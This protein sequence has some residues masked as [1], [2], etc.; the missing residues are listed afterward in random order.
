MHPAHIVHLPTPLALRDLDEQVRQRDVGTVDGDQLPL[1]ILPA[2]AALLAWEADGVAQV[3]AEF[4]GA[5]HVRNLKPIW[6]DRFFCHCGQSRY[7]IAQDVGQSADPDDGRQDNTKPHSDPPPH[8]NSVVENMSRYKGSQSAKAVE[9]DFPH[10][11]DMNVPVGGL[12][13]RLDAMYDFHTQ[14]GIKPQRGHGRH[15]ANGSVIRWRFADAA[16]AKSFASV[17]GASE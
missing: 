11:V 13:A 8:S 9:R 1:L 15:D 6:H 2:P 16:I 3:V 4:E 14:Y 10:F 17:F 7:R 5:G 12:G